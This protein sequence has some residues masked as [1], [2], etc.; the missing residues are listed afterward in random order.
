MYLLM[1]TVQCSLWLTVNALFKFLVDE[2]ANLVLV[3]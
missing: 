1:T 2:V 3:H